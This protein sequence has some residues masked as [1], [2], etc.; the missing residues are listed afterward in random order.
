M[1]NLLILTDFKKAIAYESII[2]FYTINILPIDALDSISKIDQNLV[3][4]DVENPRESIIIG[5]KLRQINPSVNILFI[6]DF[7]SPAEHFFFMKLQGYGK[8]RILR[9]RSSYPDE[10]LLSIQALFHP[11]YAYKSSDIAIIIPVYNEEARFNKVCDFIKKVKILFNES[12]SNINIYFVN[13]GSKDNTQELI[14]KLLEDEFQGTDI[15]TNQSLINVYQL[16]YNTRKAGTFIEAINSINSNIMIFV[17]G[18]NSFDIEDIA[19][20]INVLSMG[21]YDF[22]IG[23]KDLTAEN[24]AI[25][26]RCMSFVKRIITKPL[27]PKGVFDS[28]TGLKGM[29]S[30]ASRLILPYMHE[31]TGLAVDLEMAFIAKKLNF[32]VLQLPVQCIDQEGSHVDIIKDSIAFIKNVIKLITINRK[33]SLKNHDFKL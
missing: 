3:I 20:I 12:F 7:I 23:T 25:L 24:R 22:V 2:I 27:L 18:D 9:W 13:D 33:I 6:N 31:D 16:Q 1:D 15:I 5:N 21:Y 28:Q 30:N 17:D 4:I 14:D 8:T 10:L 32:R 29:T 26:R 11:E 19:K